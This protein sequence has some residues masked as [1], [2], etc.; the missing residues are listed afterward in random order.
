MNIDATRTMLT[1]VVTIQVE[2]ELIDQKVDRIRELTHGFARHP[3]FVSCSIHKSTDNTRIVEYIQ[4]ENL[5]ALQAAAPNG[6]DSFHPAGFAL[7]VDVAV[8]DVV[9]VVEP[10]G[11]QKPA[12]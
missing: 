11:G 6:L 10:S 7:D 5:A 4:W 9:E 12:G 8:L 3:G 2:P 1:L